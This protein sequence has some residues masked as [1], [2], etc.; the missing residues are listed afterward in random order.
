MAGLYLSTY[1]CS[2]QFCHMS[3]SPLE[4]RRADSCEMGEEHRHFARR[5]T[6]KG[7]RIVFNHGQSTISCMI[8]DLSSGGARLEVPSSLGIGDE[9]TLAFDDGSASRRCL[10]R[11]RSATSL[12]VEF[13]VEGPPFAL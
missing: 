7:G 1:Q 2:P 4:G 3:V 5:R 12:G 9:F 10:V 13:A 6:L 11:R 8:R